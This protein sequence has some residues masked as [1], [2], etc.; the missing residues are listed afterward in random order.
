MLFEQEILYLLKGLI[1]LQRA[2]HGL[3]AGAGV[4]AQH[5]AACQSSSAGA[6]A[7]RSTGLAEVWEASSP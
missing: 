4:A 5:G 6:Q 2:E 3:P 7:S 1:Q